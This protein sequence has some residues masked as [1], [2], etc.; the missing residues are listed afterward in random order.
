MTRPGCRHAVVH[1]G[2][3]LLAGAVAGTLVAGAGGLIAVV[4]EAV[5]TRIAG[6]DVE[7]AIL[8]VPLFLG[9]FGSVVGLLV[10]ALAGALTLPLRGR[11]NMASHRTAAWVVAWL[12]AVPGGWLVGLW[13]GEGLAVGSYAAPAFVAASGFVLGATRAAA[14]RSL[15]FVLGE[16][17]GPQSG[18]RTRASA[19]TTPSTSRDSAT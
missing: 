14:A 8:H 11:A 2:R 4:L 18:A 6:G 10:G 13:W 1:L 16:P 5:P 9:G 19:S 7:R 17:A 3:A 15:V 12:V